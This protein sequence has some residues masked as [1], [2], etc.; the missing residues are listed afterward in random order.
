MENKGD[1][2]VRWNLSSFTPPYVKVSECLHWECFMQIPCCVFFACSLFLPLASWES[3]PFWAWTQLV[4]LPSRWLCP[5]KG[6]LSL[7]FSS[8]I[9]L[10]GNQCSVSLFLV[11]LVAYG[12]CFCSFSVVFWIAL[13]V[14]H[15]WKMCLFL[16]QNANLTCPVRRH[17]LLEFCS[18]LYLCR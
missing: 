18:A 16:I 15:T 6:K 2:N 8:S 1:E 9:P 3:M 7:F 5:Y 12:A 10:A 4:S 11:H 17:V 13:V 14:K